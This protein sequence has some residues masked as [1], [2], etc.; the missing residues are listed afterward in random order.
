[1]S[2]CSNSGCN[3]S[4]TNKCSACLRVSYCGKEC[5]KAHYPS[6]K[7]ACK[8]ARAAGVSSPNLGKVTTTGSKYTSTPTGLE[9]HQEPHAIRSDAQKVHDANWN[10]LRKAR[11]EADQFFSA[12]KWQD[13]INKMKECLILASKLPE[14]INTSETVQLHIN[15]SNAYMR[16]EQISKA[17]ECLS[18]AI[19]AGRHLHTIAPEAGKTKAL[20]LICAACMSKVQNTVQIHEYHKHK[21]N[22]NVDMSQKF[23]QAIKEANEAIEISEKYL[24]KDSAMLFKP[25][26]LLALVKD[27]EGKHTEAEQLMHKAHSYIANDPD[28]KHGEIQQFVCEELMKICMRRKDLM[29]GLQYA[30]EDYEGIKRKNFPEDH[31]IHSD[32]CV[33]RAQVQMCLQAHI[34]ESEINLLK[35]LKIRE[36]KLGE[37]SVPVAD[38][39]VMISKVREAMKNVSEADNESLLLR[40]KKIYLLHDG[41]QKALPFHQHIDADIDRIRALRNNVPELLNNNMN[42]IQQ[43]N[44]NGDVFAKIIPTQG[45]NRLDEDPSDKN[46]K[47]E[48]IA[49]NQKRAKGIRGKPRKIHLVHTNNDDLYEPTAKTSPASS[50]AP[51]PEPE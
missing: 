26:R 44:S 20:E 37:N 18:K 27:C 33:R 14:P 42:H 10:S 19:S 5:Q 3:K 1:M 46:K 30:N 43:Q 45:L 13:F 28:I 24:P 35:A 6:H 34:A 48:S 12:N 16:M 25:V 8:A 9:Q 23:I 15:A 2:V 39:L 50:P 49:T 32:S 4:A 21:N 31:L 41:V 29:K 40:A 51:V 11:M 36:N 47:E 22:S 17:E 38:V 7:S